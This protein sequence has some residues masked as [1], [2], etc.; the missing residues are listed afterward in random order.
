MKAL[1]FEDRVLRLPWQWP[2]AYRFPLALRARNQ[3]VDVAQPVQGYC[4]RASEPG[5]T[6]STLP[7]LKRTVIG[8][9]EALN[10]R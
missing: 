9:A 2:V 7:S 6:L 3:G 5:A 10:A 1:S 4:A 8:A